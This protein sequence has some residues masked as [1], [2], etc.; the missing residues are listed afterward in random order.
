MPLSI[1]L[2]ENRQFIVPKDLGDAL[3]LRSVTGPLLDNLTANLERR[4]PRST[5]TDPK[6]PTLTDQ[7]YLKSLNVLV[8]L[9]HDAIFLVTRLAGGNRE[10]D[11]VREWFL[12]AAEFHRV[13]WNH[14]R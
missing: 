6:R 5:N 8:D 12:R 11:M 13:L 9:T 14:P 10:D 1:Y 7:D 4:K 2:I 3:L